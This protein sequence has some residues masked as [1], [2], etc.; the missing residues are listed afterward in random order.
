MLYKGNNFSGELPACQDEDVFADCN[1]AQVDPHTPIF[2]GVRGLVFVRC[3]LV[4][5]DLPAGTD[6]IE[7]NTSQVRIVTHEDGTQDVEEVE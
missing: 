6:I 7:C 3:N 4:N 2:T 5:C 1:L